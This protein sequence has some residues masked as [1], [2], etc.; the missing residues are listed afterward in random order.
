M[1]RRDISMALLG[2][3]AG[4]TLLSQQAQAQVCSLPCYYPLVGTET[5]ETVINYAFPYG[6]WCRYG[7]VPGAAGDQSFAL[8]RAIDSGA[9]RVYCDIGG[10]ISYDTT[11]IIDRAIRFEGA[12]SC[13]GDE[14]ATGNRGVATTRLIYTGSS[15]AIRLIGSGTEGREN[16]HL[17][18]F[19]LWG[20]ASANDGIQVGFP[21]GVL[22]TKS[23]LKNIHIKGF[24]KAGKL[25][26]RFTRALET[27]CENVYTQSCYDGIGNITTDVATTI[28][29]VNCHS[30][31]NTRYGMNVEGTYSGSSSLGLVCEG[32]GNAGLHINSNDVSGTD[33]HSYYSEANNLTGGAAPIVI[34]S[35]ALNIKFF[36]GYIADAVSGKS[37]D[38][39]VARRIVFEHVTLTTYNAGFMSVTSG[40]TDIE[41]HTAVSGLGPHLITGNAAGRARLRS[42]SFTVTLANAATIALPYVSGIISVTNVTT[43]RMAL[44]SLNGANNDTTKLV[45]SV[46]SAFSNTTGNPSTVNVAYSSGYFLQNST[47]GTSTFV[48]ALAQPDSIA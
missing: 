7:V 25:G 17:S 2:S 36:G 23:S 46:T 1:L 31:T 21:T 37:I 19:S 39:Q 33:F 29:L 22:V 32:N 20:N 16:V 41:F 5:V 12:G 26:V 28:R 27:L 35:G 30:R 40:S 24:T 43:G 18:N 13:G 38:I 48:I 10:D 3:V 15:D 42:G 4:S 8:Q 14:N 6:H 9:P 34:D 47:G 11:L 44:F 45:E